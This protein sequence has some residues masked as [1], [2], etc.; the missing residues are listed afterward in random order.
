MAGGYSQGKSSAGDDGNEDGRGVAWLP[1]RDEAR[2]QRDNP[3]DQAKN[4][5]R[6]SPQH[7]ADDTPDQKDRAGC[8][9]LNLPQMPR[10]MI[11]VSAAN[12]SRAGWQYYPPR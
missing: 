4:D 10:R 8:H 12:C 9:D 2:A 1:R 6:P 7:E 11:C 5:G 3:R